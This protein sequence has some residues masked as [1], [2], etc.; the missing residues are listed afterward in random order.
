LSHE[1]TCAPAEN[2]LSATAAANITTIAFFMDPLLFMLRSAVI[3]Q[4]Y[5]RR[6][7][8]APSR[9]DHTFSLEIR[10]P[11]T[12]KRKHCHKFAQFKPR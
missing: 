6:R 4:F 9:N 3:Y 8:L 1:R 7:Q 12:Q 10:L 11:W 2:A 5:P